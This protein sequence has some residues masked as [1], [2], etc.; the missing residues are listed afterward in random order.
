M[1]QLSD[2]GRQVIIAFFP[3]SV[4]LINFVSVYTV[5]VM[6]GLKVIRHCKTPEDLIDLIETY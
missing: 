2:S 4:H 6:C 5:Y 1:H 3:L